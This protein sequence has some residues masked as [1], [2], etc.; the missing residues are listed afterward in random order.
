MLDKSVAQKFIDNIQE[1]YKMMDD[2][3]VNSAFLE[4][5]KELMKTEKRLKE[6]IDGEYYSK[7]KC[8]IPD[9]LDGSTEI[10]NYLMNAWDEFTSYREY[11]ELYKKT[12]QDDDLQMAHDELGHFLNNLNDVYRELAEICSDNMDECSM[13]KSKVKEVYQMFH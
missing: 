11:K 5:L 12:K 9:D 3:N 1:E 7:D 6:V 2:N 8:K 10:D 4:Y 13:A